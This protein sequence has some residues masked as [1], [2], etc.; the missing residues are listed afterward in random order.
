VHG[1]RGVAEPDPN[2][3]ELGFFFGKQVT[4]IEQVVKMK[5]ENNQ[6]YVTPPCETP[7]LYAVEYRVTYGDL[8]RNALTFGKRRKVRIRYICL[9]DTNG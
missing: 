7:G 3:Q 8:L 1:Q 2:N 6:V 5:L 9:K 4:P